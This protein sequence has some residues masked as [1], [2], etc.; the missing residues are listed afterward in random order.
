MKFLDLTLPTPAENLALDEALLNAVDLGP[1]PPQTLPLAS[2]AASPLMPDQWDANSSVLRIWRAGQ[3]VVVLGRSSQLRQEVHVDLA[4][5]RGIPILRRFSGGATVVVGPGCLMYSLLIHLDSKPGLRMLDVAHSWIMGRMLQAI[6]RIEPSVNFQG[7]CDL[8]LDGRKF[9]GN[10]LRVGRQWMLYHG[11]LLLD[12]QLSLIDE[13]LLHPP[14]EPSYR[15]G[16]PHE[17][18]VTNLNV[19]ESTLIHAL[20]ESWQAREEHESPPLAMIPRLVSERYEC[21]AWNFQR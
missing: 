11:T 3:P 21:D 18:F 7:T 6:R 2:I 16:R 20:R 12:M 13:L 17:N 1:R 5:R 10:S 9:S 14:R 8:T 4:R 15:S 19:D